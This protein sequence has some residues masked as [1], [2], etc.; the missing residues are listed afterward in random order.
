MIL[1]FGR[2]SFKCQMYLLGLVL[3]FLFELQNDVLWFEYLVLIK[4]I[5]QLVLRRYGE[6]AVLL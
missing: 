1:N 3:N 4:G 6:V 5:F 2:L